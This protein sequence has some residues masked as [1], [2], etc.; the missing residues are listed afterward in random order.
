MSSASCAISRT[1][2][3]GS[4]TTML[5]LAF[6]TTSRSVVVAEPASS[7]S[8]PPGASAPIAGPAYKRLRLASPSTGMDSY[9]SGAGA[10]ARAQ[11]GKTSET[12]TS[13]DSA[14]GFF[15]GVLLPLGPDE[16][17]LSRRRPRAESS[18]LPSG[19]QAQRLPLGEAGPQETPLPLGNIVDGAAGVPGVGFRIEDGGG[20]PGGP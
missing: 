8:P 18:R 19:D 16:R 14:S 1:E 3:T 10:R 17:S 9:V 20:G 13:K 11:A 2:A 15:M 4:G 7:P 6:I 12:K 5:R